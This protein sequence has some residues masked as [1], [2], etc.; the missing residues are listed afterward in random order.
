MQGEIPEYTRT[1]LTE[2]AH[3]AVEQTKKFS[4]SKF[5]PESVKTKIQ[6]T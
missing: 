6:Q 1:A 2:T 3:A 4:F 5:I